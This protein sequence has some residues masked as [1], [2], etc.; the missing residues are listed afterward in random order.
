MPCGRMST[1]A[2]EAERAKEVGEGAGTAKAATV[3]D[4]SWVAGLDDKAKRVIELL[5]A[6]SK[7]IEELNAMT[8]IDREAKILEYVE[9]ESRRE[10][11]LKLKVLAKAKGK[12]CCNRY[13]TKAYFFSGSVEVT[14][15]RVTPS[16]TV[17]TVTATAPTA[18][19]LPAA[20]TPD[21]PS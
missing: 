20:A 2:V 19:A 21:V 11:Q 16:A 12:T 13:N 10:K 18:S 9:E 1:K 15:V 6:G 17:P 8:V 4:N 7:E 14:A 5:P 3:Y